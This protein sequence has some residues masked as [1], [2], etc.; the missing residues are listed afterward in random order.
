M[1]TRDTVAHLS[2]AHPRDDVR[3][4]H[5]ECVS[6]A[7]AGFD[8]HLFVAD[9][10]GP[11]QREGVHIHDI[12]SV[13]GRARR[14]LLQPWRMW[15]RARGLRARLYH[16]HDPEL[17]P[18]AL[19]LRAAGHAVIY[20]AHEDVPRAVLS[21]FWIKPW[22]RW[23]VATLFEA[24]EDFAARRF[25]AVVTATPHIARR[26]ARL[27]ARTVDI[28][29]YPLQLELA[30]GGA[31]ATAGRAVCYVGGIGVIRGALEMVGA[32]EAL[33]ATLILAGSFENSATEARVRA[34]P[35]WRNV[36]YRG[37]VSRDEVGRIMASSRAGLLFFHPEPNH[38]DAQPNKMF[39]YMAAGLPVLASDFALWRQLLTDTGA[40][41]CADPRDAQ[42]IA[43]CVRALLDDPQ[44][45]VAMG[46]RGRAAVQHR[47]HWGH[48]E[49]KLRALYATVLQ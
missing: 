6:L 7:A 5:K 4:F 2:T 38:V 3:I 27:N 19:L 34:L 25:S 23:L 37:K 11:A 43:R 16:F 29:N 12:G 9:G 36:D 46:E 32:F 1:S 40:G 44:E 8:V 22:L 47:Y 14:M 45:A 15:R 26:F 18:V 35:G 31:A 48:E 13:N 30:A 21:K 41:R 20:D 28:N 39:E 10:K 42:D 24:L 17:I 49:Q 33:D